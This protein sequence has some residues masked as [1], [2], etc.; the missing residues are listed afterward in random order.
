M[1]KN[2]NDSSVVL[3]QFEANDASIVIGYLG[4]DQYK[5]KYKDFIG[6]VDSQYLV[7]NDEIDDLFYEFQDRE[8]LKTIEQEELRRQK[9]KEIVNNIR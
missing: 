5:I 7:F 6:F 2:Q 4:K 3:A 8:R 9:I 1:N